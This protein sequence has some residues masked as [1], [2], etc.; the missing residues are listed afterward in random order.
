MATDTIPPMKKVQQIT[1]E[2]AK[3]LAEA[4][5]IAEQHEVKQLP[6]WADWERAMPTAIS[7]SALFAPI[8]R[9]RRKRH[10]DAVIDSR[11]DVHLTYTGEQFDM[12]DADVFMQILEFAKRHPLG[13]RF[14]V[15][16]AQV[17]DAI[18]RTYQS[19]NDAGKVRK[20]VIG[21][22]DYE[23]LDASMKRLKEG[24]LAFSFPNT[25]KRKARGGVLNPLHEW[26]WDNET[27]S[28]SISIS[29]EIHKLFES[30]SRIYL[31]KHL[32]LP[33]ADQLAKWMHLW[34]AGCAKGEVV[35]IGLDHLRDYSG[36]KHRRMDHFATSIERAMQALETAEI[37]APGWFIRA[38]N[39]MLNF[40]RIT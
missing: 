33:K 13:S 39:R 40:T 34:V 23:W 6:L 36:N 27:D 35:K 2:A 19:T 29:P 9:G 15:R 25:G 4:A 10:I 37:V 20:S 8:A 3:R 28:Y 17:L 24:S 31:E 5:A 22:N 18:N 16:R 11:K 12:S 7:R 26:L 14:S 1:E 32:A 21:K 30:F 38:N